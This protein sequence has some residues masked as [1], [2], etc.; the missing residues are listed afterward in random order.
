MVPPIPLPS[1]IILDISSSMEYV[2]LALMLDC[3]ADITCVI[4]VDA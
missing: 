4:V 1:V 3:N 2:D